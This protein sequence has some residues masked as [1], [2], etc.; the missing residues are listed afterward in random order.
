MAKG[1]TYNLEKV[2]KTSEMGTTRNGLLGREEESQ[3][4]S[5]VYVFASPTETKIFRQKSKIEFEA[6][7]LGFEVSTGSG[8]RSLGFFSEG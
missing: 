1:Q 7:G 4:A 8:P 5:S 2:I 3:E 6:G